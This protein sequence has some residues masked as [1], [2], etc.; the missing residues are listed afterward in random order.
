M[1]SVVK[2]NGTYSVVYYEG[3]GKNRHQVWESGLSHKA[4]QARKA[5]IEYEVTRN[6]HIDQ[7]NMSVSDFLHEFLEKYGKEHWVAS[8]YSS[9]VGLLENYV[10]PYLGEKKLTSIRTKTVDDYYHFLLNEA[11]P[12][13]N[14]G[15]PGREHVT[16]SM[17]HDI[18]KVLRRAWNQAVKWEYVAK[19][20]FLNAT[21]PEHKEKKRVALTPEQLSRVLKFTN[22]PEIY[23]Y[24]MLHCAIQLSFACSMRGGEIGGAQ[25]AN[26]DEENQMLHIDRVIDR[27]NKRLADSL[28]KMSVVYRFPNAYPGTRS[29]IVLKQP[30]TEGSIRNAYVPDTVA[31]KLRVLYHLQNEM[32]LELGSDGYC[33]H[34]MIICQ[35]NGKPIMTE[36]LNKR[37]KD[38]LRA[39]NDPE[40]N[41]DEIVFHSIR[42]TSA[43]VKLRLSKGDLKAVQGDGG[44][45]TPD[46]VT[47]RYA[48][49]MDEDRKILAEQ[50][51]RQFY[52]NQP[53]EGQ[54]R[55]M[56]VKATAAALVSALERDPELLAKV[57]KAIQ[58]EQGS[59]DS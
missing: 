26:Y 59:R 46:M 47:K 43:T 15:K 25:W 54:T 27:V 53:E 9:N 5:Q 39:M 40:I 30:K 56:P 36:H 44:W 2:R 11:E 35:A 41:P 51:E 18:H 52:Q 14:R 16:A 8:T 45:S 23:D 57:L 55:V 12:V 58:A 24:Y 19:N 38:V 21:L 3:E 50:M 32:K 17:V 22:R 6:I 7:N 42:H 1:A 13:A 31:R 34:D 10:Y 28:S 33:D 20:P 48:H 4:A 37:F 49:I 29:A